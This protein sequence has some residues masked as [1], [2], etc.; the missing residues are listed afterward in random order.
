MG[1]VAARGGVRRQR[2]AIAVY[3]L[4]VL[5][6]L[7]FLFP[8][9]WAVASSFRPLNDVFRYTV[10]FSWRAFVPIPF[11]VQP[12]VVVLQSGFTRALVNTLFVGLVTVAAGV[13]ANSLA[14]FAFGVFRFRGQR[15]LF[16]F[17]VLTFLVPFEAIVIPLYI[18]VAAFGWQNTFQAL[19]VPAIANGLVIFLFRQFFAGLPRELIEAARVDGLSWFGVWA[20]I[21]M[22]LSLPVIVT[23]SMM[24]FLTQ[25]QS[26]FWPLLVA[27][28]PQYQMVQVALT[29]FQ[30][31][32]V[33]VW[34]QLFAAATITSIV[35]VIMLLGLQRYYIQSVAGTGLKG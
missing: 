5:V 34:N 24:L 33:T 25:W 4:L 13:L 14:G 19:I 16:S 7:A 32:Y 30:T 23:A 28:G 12:Y 29:N 35:P 15:V 3:L 26:F 8:L 20:R 18:M 22:P 9:L 2:E 17:V 10:P 27:N 11:T 21:A 6:A 31:Q 1:S